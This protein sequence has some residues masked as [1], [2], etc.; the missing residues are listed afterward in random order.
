MVEKKEYM[1]TFLHKFSSINKRE[2]EN[3][4]K[5]CEFTAEGMSSRDQI[6]MK[7]DEGEI[8]LEGKLMKYHRKAV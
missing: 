5:K 1:E 4:L 2:I 8:E 7:P 3:A 6:V